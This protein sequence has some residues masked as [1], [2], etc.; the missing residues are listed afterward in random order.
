MLN[1]TMLYETSVLVGKQKIVRIQAHNLKNIP[2][3][4]PP[5]RD[6]P[7][8]EGALLLEVET[9]DGIIGWATSGYTHHVAIDLIDKYL[10]PRI[11]G[12]QTDPFRT[13]R[14]PQLFDRH[15]W[16][17]PLGRALVS[18]LAMI[19][20]ACWDIKGKTMGKPVH[21]LIGGAR[22]RVPVYV[23][24]GAAYDGAPVYSA[25]ELAAEA[26]HLVTL[27]NTHLKNTVG[28]QAIP[29]PK[30][31]YL[32]MAAMREAVGPGIQLS[33]DGNLRMSL[34]QAVE[35]C[36]RC[37]ELDISFI[38][39]PVHYNE[40]TNLRH[41]RSRTK[42]SVAAAEN[43]K[44]SA[45][46][47]LVADAVDIIQPNINNDGGLTAGLRTAALARAFNVPLGHGN[48]NGPHNIALHAGVGNGGLVEYH[49]HKW[50]SYNAIFNDVPQPDKGWLDVSQEPGFGLEP[51][52]GLIKEYAAR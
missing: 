28:R 13:E 7:N 48:G 20:I 51:K 24:H 37:E 4:P 52:D 21:H 41:L 43:E 42:I 19:D 8:V 23:T 34:P 9:S 25:E 33:M 38:E 32:R 26:A 11:I 29:D 30:D 5:F 46:D 3:T 39:E 15:T 16:E 17:R 50:M 44:F 35:L 2:I 31:D 1:Q 6:R 40:P 10:A 12:E 49:F 47:L 18:A 45:R 22:D 27:G 14:I 36:N